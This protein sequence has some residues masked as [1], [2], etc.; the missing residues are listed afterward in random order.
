MYTM[1]STLLLCIL[2]YETKFHLES[3]NPKIPLVQFI[4]QIT[5]YNIHTSLFFIQQI[6]KY[7]TLVLMKDKQV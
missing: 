4:Q 5:S 6:Y 3:L 7:V 1:L 2:Y